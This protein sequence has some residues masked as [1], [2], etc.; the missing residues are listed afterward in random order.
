MT[1]IYG[2]AV[3]D[4]VI[5]EFQVPPNELLHGWPPRQSQEAE[6]Q[7]LPAPQ[8]C[9]W[10]KTTRKWDKSTIGQTVRVKRGRRTRQKRVAYLLY[11]HK[12]EVV[13]DE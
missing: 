13:V 7:K 3:P 11:N 1:F 4:I 2:I 6:R 10:N 8:Q 9:S 12:S 5:I